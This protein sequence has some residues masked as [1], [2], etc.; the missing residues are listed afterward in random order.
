MP[1]RTNRIYSKVDKIRNSVEDRQSR[2]AWQTVNEIS[3]RKSILNVK[4][5][6][7]RIQMW[8]EHFR[9]T[10]KLI[11]KIINNQ[12]EIKLGMFTPKELNVVQTKIKTRKTAVP[13]KITP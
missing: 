9:V 6:E 1:K 12:L 8:K 7:E 10:D 3:K 5:K 13:D 4:L 11:S 2:I